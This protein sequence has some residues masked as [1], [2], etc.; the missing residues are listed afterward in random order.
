[1][2]KK[3]KD[4][5]VGPKARND[6]YVMMLFITLVAIITGS[7][8]MYLDNEEYGKTAPPK[9]LVFSPPKLGEAPA[10]APGPGPGGGVVPPGGPGDAK[11][12]DAKGPDAKGGEVPKTDPKGME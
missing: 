1:M 4:T 11:G 10:P 9:D 6:A 7:V 12:P 2:A 8:L 3:D 5:P